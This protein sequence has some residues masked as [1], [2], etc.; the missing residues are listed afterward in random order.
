MLLAE[1]Q[2]ILQGLH[3]DA[4]NSQSYFE[5]EGL[6]HGASPSVGQSGELGAA[7]AANSKILC[8]LEVSS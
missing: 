4:Y 1:M 2:Y 5:S 8:V 6:G 7:L 3:Q